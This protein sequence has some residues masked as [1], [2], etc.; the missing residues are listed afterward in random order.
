MD[1][2]IKQICINFLKEVCILGFKRIFKMY[3]VIFEYKNVFFFIRI[4]KF[5]EVILRFIEV[6][7]SKQKYQDLNI[8]FLYKLFFI[9][10]NFKLVQVGCYKKVVREL[11]K[12]IWN[13]FCFEG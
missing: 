13:D 7:R 1:V 4:E 3:N 5:R 10:E 6:V 12:I 2:S 9:R 8:D 11:G